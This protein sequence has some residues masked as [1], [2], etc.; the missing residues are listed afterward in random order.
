[1]SKISIV[2]RGIVFSLLTLGEY[3]LRLFV[4]TLEG[5]KAES[6]VEFKRPTRLLVSGTVDHFDPS[7]LPLPAKISLP[8]KIKLHPRYADPYSKPKLAQHQSHARLC[9]L[10]PSHKPLPPCLL[11]TLTRLH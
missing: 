6:L 9:I 4:V 10:Y 3:L 11:D 5:L 1:M 7:F 2:N 8:D